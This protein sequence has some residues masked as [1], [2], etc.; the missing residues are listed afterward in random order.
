MPV[1][2]DQLDL[3]VL[4]GQERAVQVVTLFLGYGVEHPFDHVLEALKRQDEAR[5]E[6]RVGD[7][8]IILLR[9]TEDLEFALARP[10]FERLVLELDAHRLAIRQRF[11]DL[12]E[13]L[14]VDR[15][16][17]GLFDIRPDMGP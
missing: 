4:Q 8:R 3:P 5:I 15:D 1:R 10:D 16:G 13:L 2:A 12:E 9:K 14:A 11:D 17:P 7:L 6:L